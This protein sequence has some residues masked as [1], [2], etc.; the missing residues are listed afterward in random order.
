MNVFNWRI[1]KRKNSFTIVRS[2]GYQEI[3]KPVVINLHKLEVFDE[4]PCPGSSFDLRLE[5]SQSLMFD[6]KL[7]N[8]FLKVNQAYCEVINIT[9]ENCWYRCKLLF[10]S[11]L[12]EEINISFRGYQSNEVSLFKSLSKLSIGK[13]NIDYAMWNTILKSK[14]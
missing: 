7:C 6:S 3:K 12:M 11:Y 2:V 9:S 4:Y 1:G 5:I 14:T 13:I 8:E 10:F